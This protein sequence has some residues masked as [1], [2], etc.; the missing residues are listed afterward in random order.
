MMR[1]VGNSGTAPTTVRRKS[2]QDREGDRRAPR[3]AE[4]AVT[5]KVTAP[6]FKLLAYWLYGP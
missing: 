5:V 6:Q 3:N 1:Q 2:G 4:G